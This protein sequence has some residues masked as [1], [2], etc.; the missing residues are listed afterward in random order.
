[1][2]G[3]NVG[4]GGNV[5]PQHEL[6]V[7][8]N[9]YSN[10]I[11][12]IIRFDNGV[13]DA[14]I[15]G[16]TLLDVT[17]NGNNTTETLRFNHPTTSFVTTSNVGIA[18][19]NPLDA[20]AVTGNAYISG[21]LTA[22]TIR[23]SMQATTLTFSS[24]PGEIFN[25]LSL[26]DICDAGATYVGSSNVGIGTSTPATKL[27][28]VGTVTATA[29]APFTGVHFV[30]R[31]VNNKLPDGSIMVSTGKVEKR[32]TIDTVPEVIRSTV[33]KQKTVLGASHYDAQMGKTVVISLGEGQVLVC[34]Q[35]GPILNGDYICSSSREGIG[36]KQPD[37]ILHSYTV[38]KATEDCLFENGERQRLVACTFHSG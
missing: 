35:N 28:V 5:N 15:Q 7:E 23:G 29:Y 2:S 3:S 24:D 4:L 22:E 21:S 16:L 38:A 30:S 32:T 34:K 27:E 9:T 18:N 37:D 26:Q 17:Q 20:L 6:S 19:T 12:Q 25:T 1:M 14:V 13:E 36:M 31:P 10:L 11:T 8:G 33:M